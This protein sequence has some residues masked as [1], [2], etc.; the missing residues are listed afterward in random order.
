LILLD[1]HAWI[2]WVSAPAMLSKPAAA[3]IRKASSIGVSAIS[4]WELTLLLQKGRLSLDRPALEWM[5]SSLSA[6][7]V[8]LLPM[9]PAIVVT[10]MDLNM[11]GDP[12]DRLIAGTALAENRVLVTR[13]EKLRNA[14]FLRTVW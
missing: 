8:S 5:T 9:S 4:C 7:K 13:D 11:H 6:P 3:A 1:T 10:V 2:W 14:A 12:G